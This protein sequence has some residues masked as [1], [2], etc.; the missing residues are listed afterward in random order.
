MENKNDILNELKTISPLLAG[1][2]KINVFSIPEEYFKKLDTYIIEI[3]KEN[4]FLQHINKQ[5]VNEIP[6]GYF[7]NLSENIL[8]KI[9]NQ[10]TQNALE[11]IKTL[12]PTLYQLQPINVFKLPGTY[13]TNLSNEILQKINVQPDTKVVTFRKYNGFL[14]YA[15]AAIFAGAMALG[16]FKFTQPSAVGNTSLP[17]YVLDAQ[18]I[19]NIDE[20][21][22]KISETDIIKYLQDNGEDVDAALVSITIDEKNLPAEEDYLTDEKALDNYLDNLYDNNSTTN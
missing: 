3:A 15:I 19:K 6:L 7:T 18:K 12:S 22:A 8:N 4:N 9:K 5:P 20:E 11:E 16:I 1:I 2:E 10:Q 13:F 21:L 14:K 17:Q